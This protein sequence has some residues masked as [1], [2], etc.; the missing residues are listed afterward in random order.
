MKSVLIIALLLLP[1]AVHAQSMSEILGRPTDRS[2]TLNALF[3]VPVEMYC[4][5]GTQSKQ[6]LYKTSTTTTVAGEPLEVVM[7]NLLPNTRYYYRT[8]Y[9]SIGS[10]DF[11][12]GLEHTFHTQRAKGSTF[13]FTIQ[14]D[15]HLY[16]KKGVRRLMD[17]TMKNQAH[18]SADFLIDLG[19]TFGDDHTPTT[20]TDADMKQLHLDYR[21]VFG[22]TC[23]S[24][25]LFLCLGNHEGEN[26]YY[27]RDNPPNNIAI[28][29]TKWRQYYYP[30][31]YPDGFYSGNEEEEEYGI[32]RPENYYAWEWGDA[33]FIVLDMYRYCA[34]SVKPRGWDWTLGE[35][36]YKWFQKTI[37]QS[38]AKYKFVFAHH[39]LGETR[40]AIT[41]APLY[42][43]GGYEGNGRNWGFTE[44]RPGWSKPIHQ[45]MVDNGVTV[46][47]QGHDHLF[48][49][50]ELDGVVYH[51]VPMPSDS[52][53]EI[54]VLANADAYT[55]LTLDG[56]GHIRV[57]VS[58]DSVAVSFIRAYLPED[59]VDGRKNGEI[60]HEYS[61]KS[62]ANSSV[63]DNDLLTSHHLYQN[64]PNP[65]H[66]R[67][68][69]TFEAQGKTKISLIIYDIAGNKVRTLY[70]QYIFTEEPEEYICIWD[71]LSD[72]HH[73]VESGV[74][75]YE[76]NING[77]REVKKLI[78]QR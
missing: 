61:V 35:A 20:T 72:D 18:D 6:Y 48:A 17:I 57:T 65:V 55:D 26:G 19:D 60:A 75:Y 46:F 64:H 16:D 56:S 45:L 21:P 36:Q 2:I 27:L 29:G 71:G 40:G 52:T 44:N 24:S 58:P 38:K 12:A 74:Y 3:N 42:E 49:K 7:R 30:N 22:L 67:T 43:W 4:E 1:F 31:P 53:Y 33:L 50:E 47:F 13:S 37:E 54:G 77:H 15:P 9:R 32:G 28:Y 73:P 11:V 25:P 63:I 70:D 66:T 41:S 76:L 78:L 10:T 62:R 23:H 39:L 69:I 51:E 34:T 8:M 14:A 59:E 68:E 5:Y